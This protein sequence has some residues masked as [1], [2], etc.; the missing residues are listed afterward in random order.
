M[1]I[2]RVKEETLR[3]YGFPTFKDVSLSVMMCEE[4]IYIS[5]NL[6]VGGLKNAL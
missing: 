3:N 4:R 6:Y 1:K 2:G 5:K